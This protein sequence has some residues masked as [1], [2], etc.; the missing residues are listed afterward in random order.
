MEGKILGSL[1]LEVDRVH[2][3]PEV[4]PFNQVETGGLITLLAYL[5]LL[6]YYKVMSWI[7]AQLRDAALESENLGSI[8]RSATK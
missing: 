1:F 6:G 7:C 8:L 3:L 4:E 5:Q 2:S